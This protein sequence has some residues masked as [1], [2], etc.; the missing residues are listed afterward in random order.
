MRGNGRAAEEVLHVRCR[1]VLRWGLSE[2]G[3]EGAQ[4]PVRRAQSGHGPKLISSSRGEMRE[5]YCRSGHLTVHFAHGLYQVASRVQTIY[6]TVKA[7]VGNKYASVP[8]Q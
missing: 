3:L 4:G 2:G 8:V 6:H 7:R 1:G 5:Q